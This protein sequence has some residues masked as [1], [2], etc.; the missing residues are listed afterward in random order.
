MLV[1]VLEAHGIAWHAAGSLEPFIARS[2]GWLT[3][4]HCC[5][6]S[7]SSPALSRFLKSVP[8]FQG[9]I[10]SEVK[11]KN[12]QFSRDWMGLLAKQLRR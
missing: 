7:S 6:R 3:L 5:L 9:V 1:L 4:V 11:K 10:Q 12:K 8:F 2:A